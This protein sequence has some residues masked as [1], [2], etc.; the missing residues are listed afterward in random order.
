MRARLIMRSA[1][2]SSCSGAELLQNTIEFCFE[3][4]PCINT[5][6]MGPDV[7]HY[8]PDHEAREG[9]GGHLTGSVDQTERLSTTRDR[10][11]MLSIRNLVKRFGDHTILNQVSLDIPAGHV[12]ALIGG[13]GSGKTTL[14]RCVNFL[15][16]PDSGEIR[17]DGELIGVRQTAR[18]YKPLPF[19]SLRRQR[20]EIGMVFQNFNLF[21]HFTA[22][23]NIIEAPIAVR[24]V[25][26]EDAKAAAMTLL[27]EVGLAGKAGHYPSQL[28]GGQQQRV[29]IARAL[30]MKPKL[31]LFDEPTS[32]LDPELVDEVLQVMQNLAQSGVTMLVV[33]HEMSFVADVADEVVFMDGGSVVES[34][35]PLQVLRNPEHP[36][37]RVFLK[38]LLR[39]Q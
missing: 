19:R 37:T 4:G 32:A 23:E 26:R 25:P 9:A 6:L 22:L 16:T 15:E 35:P 11:P 39:G 38:R 14:L 7:S 10:T 18:G 27:H 1:A 17:L 5:A 30:A 28:S 21:P 33:T 29:A 2:W 36:R 34:G 31:L 13:S 3:V 24:K 12:V 20:A 8:R